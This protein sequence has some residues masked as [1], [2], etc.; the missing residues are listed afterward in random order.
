MIS[1]INYSWF[2]SLSKYE[3]GNAG[4]SGGEKI[5]API[6]EK[7]DW[8]KARTNNKVN[9]HMAPGLNEPRP[10]GGTRDFKLWG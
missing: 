2:S 8:S 4:S 10:R 6:P 1:H 9:T 3:F 5:E 7:N